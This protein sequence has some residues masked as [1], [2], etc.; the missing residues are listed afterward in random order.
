MIQFFE[1]YISPASP[2]RSKLAIHLRAQGVS[3]VPSPAEI[4]VGVVE[5]VVDKAM[6]QLGLKSKQVNKRT[7]YVIENVRDFKSLMAVSAGPRPVKDLSEFEELD[8]KL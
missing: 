7:P 6:D 2:M 4:P 1:H 8:S 3:E 5:E